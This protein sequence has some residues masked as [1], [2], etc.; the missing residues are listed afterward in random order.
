MKTQRKS[1]PNFGIYNS[2]PVFLAWK[3]AKNQDMNI[4]IWFLKY[5]F[6]SLNVHKNVEFHILRTPVFIWFSLVR[7]KFYRTI[8]LIIVNKQRS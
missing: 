3:F 7:R 1:K 4:Q 6:D 5:N 8:T 2:H